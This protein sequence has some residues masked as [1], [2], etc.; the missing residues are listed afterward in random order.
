MGDYKL[1]T[2]PNY[3]VPEEQRV[4]AL[5]K[6]KQMDLLQE[7]MHDTKMQ[8]NAKLLELR[9]LK[10]RLIEQIQDDNRILQTL[11]ASVKDS[12]ALSDEYGYFEPQMDMREWPEQR[13]RVV[14]AHIEAYENSKILIP[15]DQSAFQKQSNQSSFV[16][17]EAAKLSQ[18]ARVYQTSNI[19]I[20]NESYK[21]DQAILSLLEEEERRIHETKVSRQIESL[22]AKISHAIETF[23]E[24]VY[25]LRREKMKLDVILKKAEIKLMILL[26]ELLLL[27]QFESKE[28]LLVSKLEKCK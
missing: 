3:V 23:D 7:K 21:D 10:H 13:E 15:L 26:G 28:N 4:N 12:S 1:K 9:E 14:D 16:D 2:S 22:K 20:Q 19:Y 27:E 6:R 5:K 24:A 11:Y 17:N 8:F 25:R 18:V